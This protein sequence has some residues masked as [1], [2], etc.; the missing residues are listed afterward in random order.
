MAMR[1]PFV[2]GNWKM[3]GNQASADA[4]LDGV[5]EEV[6][7]LSGV[8][9]VVC[10]PFVYLEGVGRRL[11]GSNVAWGSQNVS[12]H[13]S[14]AFTGEVAVDMLK[15]FACRYAIVGHSERRTLFGETDAVVAAKVRALRAGGLTPILCVGETLEEREQG[16]TEKV[17]QKQLQAVVDAEGTDGLGDC[18]IAYEPVWAIGTGKTASPEQAQDVHAFI[19]D[20]V[21]KLDAGVAD[22]VRI[23]Y[24]GSV[25]GANAAQLFAKPDIDGGL[26]GGASLDAV[27]FGAICKAAT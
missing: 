3:N 19:R 25:K 23:L 16:V 8:D 7:G 4:L 2:A 27:E 13:A 18:V 11:K 21:A 17:V 24:G 26:I 12:E 15:D 6:H 22:S 5:V 9:V 20:Y 10:P 1:V 14:G